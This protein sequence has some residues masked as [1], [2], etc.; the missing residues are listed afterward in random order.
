MLSQIRSS[1]HPMRGECSSQ[2]RSP[3]KRGHFLRG[4]LKCLSRPMSVEHNQ[5]QRKPQ[6]FE[7]KTERIL[8][9]GKEKARRD[10]FKTDKKLSVLA[11]DLFD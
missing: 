1:T 9:Y 3:Y 10:R 2:E 6:D 5:L 11:R 4:Y 7:I 8:K